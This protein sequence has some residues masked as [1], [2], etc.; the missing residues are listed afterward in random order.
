[1]G[2]RYSRSR[3]NRQLDASLKYKKG[4]RKEGVPLR[5]DLARVAF[6]SIIGRLSLFRRRG[7]I[8]RFDKT[9]DEL[10]RLLP[11]RF[12][13]EKSDAL[14]RHMVARYDEQRAERATDSSG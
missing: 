2:R 8:E 14:I 6:A 11:D 5:D 9:V 7:Q 10:V 1:M 13:R 3:I 4:L 12:N